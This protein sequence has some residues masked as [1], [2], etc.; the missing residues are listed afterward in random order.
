M[1]NDG[2]TKIVNFDDPKR[3]V[4][5]WADP[6][7]FSS[8]AQ[9]V[10]VNVGHWWGWRSDVQAIVTRTHAIITRCGRHSLAHHTSMTLHALPDPQSYHRTIQP[11]HVHLS[12]SGPKLH[13]AL[14][15]PPY[16][17]ATYIAILT[18]CGPVPYRC[19]LTPRSSWEAIS[20]TRAQ[21]ARRSEP[22]CC[23]CMVS[24][25]PSHGLTRRCPQRPSWSGWAMRQGI[26]QPDAVLSVSV[27]AMA[28]SAYPHD[29]RFRTGC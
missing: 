2:R 22:A 1:R 26:R 21:P 16:L 3:P 19:P 17:I 9:L 29:L 5:R 4:G 10:V 24:P 25:M 15:L 23:S 28:R 20:S 8:R 12:L 14:S 11:S 13:P 7:L 6:T 18:C 27:L